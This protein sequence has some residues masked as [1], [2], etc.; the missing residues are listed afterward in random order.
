MGGSVAEE[1]EEEEEEEVNK[2][3]DVDFETSKID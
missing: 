2:L 1:E 3:S